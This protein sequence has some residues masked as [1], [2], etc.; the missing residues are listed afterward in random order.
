MLSYFL[1]PIF[2][3]LF[4][5]PGDYVPDLRFLPIQHEVP[6][7]FD[8]E[9][10]FLFLFLTL[11]SL[12]MLRRLLWKRLQISRVVLDGGQLRRWCQSF[13]LSIVIRLCHFWI[14]LGLGD[15]TYRTRLWKGVQCR[16]RLWNLYF[17]ISFQVVTFVE[18]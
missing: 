2:R 17:R 3:W 1:S 5:N 14:L 8:L 13:S 10:S 9:N 15:I 12:F 6:L 7:Y 16:T 11:L 4:S 18:W